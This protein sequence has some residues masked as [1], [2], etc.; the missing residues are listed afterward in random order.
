[1]AGRP[2]GQVTARPK[3]VPC[4]LLTNRMV[5]PVP[6]C[7]REHQVE[8]LADARPPG[9][10]RLLHDLDEVVSREVPSRG[11]S[12]LRTE[13]EGGDL[14]AALGERDRR[15]ACAAADFEQPGA[16]RQIRRSNQ[17]VEQFDRIVRP[18]SVVALGD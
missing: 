10:K 15:L 9:L 16:G 8:P 4:A 2:D 3:G 17:F 11:R 5:Y 18:G 1:M 12:Q 13:L 6:R 7:C 14:E